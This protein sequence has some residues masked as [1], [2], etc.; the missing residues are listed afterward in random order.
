MW[1]HDLASTLPASQWT[2]C[3]SFSF[4]QNS[5]RAELTDSSEVEKTSGQQWS[6]PPPL[7]PPCS[8]GI[9]DHF[10][11]SLSCDSVW[12]SPSDFPSTACVG[13]SSLCQS[14]RVG[15]GECE[16][17]YGRHMSQQPVG[18]FQD[19]CP[20]SCCLGSVDQREQRSYVEMVVMATWCWSSWTNRKRSKEHKRNDPGF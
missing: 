5:E 17:A 2:Q 16:W 1:S 10:D 14:V 3:L 12:G 7:T 15:V 13:S 6:P 9:F 8:T 18:V 11:S 20:C 19:I 4:Y